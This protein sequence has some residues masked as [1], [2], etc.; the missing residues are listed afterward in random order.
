MR[1]RLAS[2]LEHGAVIREPDNKEVNTLIRRSVNRVAADIGRPPIE[3]Q[4]RSPE[5]AVGA[6]GSNAGRRTGARVIRRKLKRSAA[7]AAAALIALQSFPRIGRGTRA[8]DGDRRIG[9]VPGRVSSRKR[10]AKC[11]FLRSLQ[12]PRRHPHTHSG[13]GAWN[14]LPRPRVQSL[15]TAAP[16]GRPG[17]RSM[18]S[19]FRDATVEQRGNRLLIR[20]KRYSDDALLLGSDLPGRH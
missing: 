9:R 11:G 3:I 5:S 7:I 4:P 13:S 19:I 1:D 14:R 16:Q 15:G 10:S 17:R 6:H 20:A 18:A 12:R 2:K 8:I